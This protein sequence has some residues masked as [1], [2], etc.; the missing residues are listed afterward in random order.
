MI[1]NSTLIITDGTTSIDLLNTFKL[2][3]WTPQ[4]AAAKGGGVWGSSPFSQGRQ[5]VLREYENIIDTFEL[6]ASGNASVDQLIYNTQE[7]RRLLEKAVSYWVTDWQ[8]EFVWIETRGICETNTRYAIIHDYRTPNDD[9]PFT[10]P[11]STSAIFDEWTLILEHGLWLDSEPGQSS[12]LPIYSCQG[13]Y[14]GRELG[15]CAP[16]STTADVVYIAN[17]R[18]EANLTDIYYYDAS[19]AAYSANLMSA[20]P[21]PF[22]ATTLLPAVPAIGDIIYFIQDTVVFAPNGGPFHSLVFDLSTAQANLTMVWE[23]YSSAG[24]GTWVALTVQDNTN[25][26]GL[27]TGNPLD[28]TGVHSVHWRTPALWVTTIINGVTGYIVRLRVT[29]A[30]GGPVAP[31]QSNR[32]IYSIVKDYVD[33]DNVRDANS[34][35][36]G[37]IDTIASIEYKNM[38]DRYGASG[39]GP[40]LYDTRVIIGSRSISRGINFNAHQ[41]FYSQLAPGVTSTGG[42]ANVEKTPTGRATVAAGSAAY[43]T[44]AYPYS[45][46]YI[47]RFRLLVRVYSSAP[48]DGAY[49]SLRPSLF[50]TTD[51]Y[52]TE[53]KQT[54]STGYNELLDFGIIE[55]TNYHAQNIGSITLF[56]TWSVGATSYF[57]DMVLLPVDEW[58]IDTYSYTHGEALA[59]TPFPGYIG[60]R[61][62]SPTE[63]Y[64]DGVGAP[65][66][67][68]YSISRADDANKTIVQPYIPVSS[69]NSVGFP[70]NER[71]RL[72]FVTEQTL[73][74]T[75]IKVSPYES[76]GQVIIRN[77][78]RYLGMRGNR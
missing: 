20:A 22:V 53:T 72:F 3:D 63:L 36:L 45:L 55:I 57:S 59:I 31:V 52:V 41:N 46:Q 58:A 34:V 49:V 19:A 11:T 73:P 29:V 6:K 21:P 26:S 51:I 33:I 27:M 74:T 24:G 10:S 2:F 40:D 9:N 17:K 70:A 71:V 37:D 56:A 25:A 42:V 75:G 15:I 16:V 69:G 66:L 14:D 13:D 18:N 77:T 32:D 35:L 61:R 4:T 47:G 39:G 62:V 8:T 64:I 48:G 23:Y 50:S 28:T 60:G 5:L 78:N 76:A 7:L 30:G 38:S 1:T 54:Q 43:I 44:I 12:A 65:K 68:A 67:G